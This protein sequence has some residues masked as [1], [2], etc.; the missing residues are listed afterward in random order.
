MVPL[1]RPARRVYS[2]ESTR[3]TLT[4]RA[5]SGRLADAARLPRSA[6]P[7]T[8]ENQPR[9]G[10]MAQS[11]LTPAL[12]ALSIALVAA[13]P[14]FASSDRG[15]F[16][17]VAF[18]SVTQELG[19]AVQSKYFSVGTDVPWAEAGVGAVATQARV[20]PSFGPKALA[21]LK[22]GLSASDVMRALA[23][24]DSVWDS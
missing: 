20:D 13:A 1:L 11:R 18:D 19:V 23:A 12:V 21:L 9:R 14:A 2:R 16:S 10:P 17:I 22:T 6:R 5:N 24:T 7:G 4:A 3:P 15:T 8:P